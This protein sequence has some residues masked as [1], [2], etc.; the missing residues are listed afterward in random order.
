[1]KNE[2]QLT[3]FQDEFLSEAAALFIA[4]FRKQRQVT[5][6]LPDLMEEP[7]K[8]INLL[9]GFLHSTPG[10]A[11]FRD[12]R[13]VGYLSWLPIN[14][15]RNMD[16]TGAFCPE[17]GHAV[18]EDGAASIYLAMYQ[19][20][21]VQWNSAGCQVYAI[22]L[23]AA[24]QPAAKF[25]F[26]NGFGMI[27][28]NAIRSTQPLNLPKQESL[29]I[30]TAQP[31]DAETI[32]LLEAEHFLHYSAPPISMAPQPH[33]DATGYREFLRR[34]NCTVCLAWI[35]NNPVGYVRFEPQGFGAAAIVRSETTIAISAAY[36]RLQFRGQGV[37][38]AL[39][40]AGLQYYAEKG[41][42]RCSVDFESTNPEASHFWL[43]YFD[44]VCISVMRIL[45]SKEVV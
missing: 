27:V 36:T 1:M 41:F 15:F 33:E 25:W 45:E 32:A 17:W 29:V 30:R 9:K 11:A 19:K 42:N 39:L 28:I 26:W 8:V 22:T 6:L 20:A 38:P 10:I 13:L 12:G 18:D 21:A 14:R 31:E 24:D 44:P 4:N 37:A 16:R 5:P 34:L 43:K 40:E 3:T 23:L 7:E 2:I 35:G